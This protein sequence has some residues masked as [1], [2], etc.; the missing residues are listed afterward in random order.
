V[1]SQASNIDS[2]D[3]RGR[4]AP[5]LP[6]PPGAHDASPRQLLGMAQ[7][8]LRRGRTGEAQQALEMAMTDELNDPA[9]AGSP[10]NN[11][12]VGDI[13]SAL[14]ALGRNDHPGAM[15]AI[16]TAMAGA[17]PG[18][19]QPRMGEA[20]MGGPGM[21]GAPGTGA[22]GVTGSQTGAAPATPR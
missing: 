9:L 2:A 10:Q 16:Q 5:R 14:Q 12:V 3:V 6:T 8:A 7:N 11:P 17:S 18:T 21:A 1:S 20:G 4:I 22:P 13:N 19:G 15:Q